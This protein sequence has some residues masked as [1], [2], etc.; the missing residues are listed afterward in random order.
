MKH[1]CTAYLLC[2]H[3]VPLHI[4]GFFL[5]PSDSSFDL[6]HTNSYHLSLTQTESYYI[7]PYIR[8][9]PSFCIYAVAFESRPL[10]VC[11]GSLC[12]KAKFLQKV[13]VVVGGHL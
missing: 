4:S 13:L 6:T 3:N 10:R 1:Q 7:S 11:R 8:M 9:T 12:I 5:T 2:G